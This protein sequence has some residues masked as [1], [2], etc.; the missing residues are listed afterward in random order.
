M[1]N[2][3]NLPFLA[4]SPY[5]DHSIEPWP[6]D[7]E[8]GRL[9]LAEAG[10]RDTDGDGI[11]DK[12][13]KQFKFI[14]MTLPASNITQSKI[15]AIFREDLG[16]AGILMEIKAVEWSVFG[17]RVREGN[18]DVCTSGFSTAGM[19]SGHVFDPYRYWHSSLADVKGSANSWG[20]KSVE[21]DR[22]L[23][24]AR[25]E[26]DHRKRIKLYHELCR[27]I[28]EEQ[29]CAFLLTPNSQ[30]AFAR[31][32]RNVKIYAGGPHINSIWVPKDEQKYKE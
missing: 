2:L 22:I 20:F 8:K 9:L 17:P 28:H 4:Q 21:T 24:K 30:W 6:F 26:F 10:W 27:I 3:V 1:G 31:R 19:R 11:L 15:A 13:G 7:I 16:K 25:G 12:D 32:F 18:F 29:P 23:D 5:Y 14:F